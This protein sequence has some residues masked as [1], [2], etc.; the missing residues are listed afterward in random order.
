MVGEDLSQKYANVAFPHLASKGFWILDLTS[1]GFGVQTLDF[2]EALAKVVCGAVV[3]AV[4][5]K[6]MVL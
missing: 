3:P 1:R 6:L 4:K 5:S 2:E